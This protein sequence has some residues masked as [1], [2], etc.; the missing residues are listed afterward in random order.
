MTSSEQRSNGMSN[1]IRGELICTGLG[2]ELVRFVHN[3]PEKHST[4]LSQSL[5]RVAVGVNPWI[6]KSF[7]LGFKHVL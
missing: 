4:A 2:S 7:G 3:W 1:G 5:V 6:L